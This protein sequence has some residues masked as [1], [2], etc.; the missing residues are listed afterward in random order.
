MLKQKAQFW[1]FL[2][3][4]RIK[5]SHHHAMIYFFSGFI[6]LICVVQPFPAVVTQAEQCLRTIKAPAQSAYSTAGTGP[7]SK[8]PV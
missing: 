2:I 8:T 3:P 7:L 4:Y 6:G 5:K 1:H